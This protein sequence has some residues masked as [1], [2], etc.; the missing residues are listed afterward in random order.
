M[1][2]VNSTIWSNLEPSLIRNGE[3]VGRKQSLKMSCFTPSVCI[4]TF[5]FPEYVPTSICCEKKRKF[6]Q[7]PTTIMDQPSYQQRELV[8][9]IVSNWWMKFLLRMAIMYLKID[10]TASHGFSFMILVKSHMVW[11]IVCEYILY[12]R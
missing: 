4:Y 7:T 10:R 6:P 1:V 5:V 9:Q 3:F 2:R 12:L 8:Y 11:N